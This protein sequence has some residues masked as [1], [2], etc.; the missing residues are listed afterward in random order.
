MLADMV[1]QEIAFESVDLEEEVFRISENLEPPALQESIREVG[2]L[3][4]VLVLK[5]NSRYTVLCGFRRAR[6]IKSLGMSA[7]LARILPD[8]NCDPVRA[9]TIAVRDNL[10]H[11]Q[12]NP[13][14]NARILFK[15]HSEFGLGDLAL[16][17]EYLP[18]LGLS[19]A[20]TVLRSYLRLHRVHPALRQCLADG[21][22]TLSSIEAL[23]GMPQGV[24]DGIAVLMGKIR[25]SASLQKK[26]LVLLQDLAGALG[27][28]PLA[29][30]DS[31]DVAAITEDQ[32]L[33][34]FQKGE[35]IFE[36]VYRLRN[37]R[38][39]QAS[40]QFQAKRKALGLAGSIR[41]TAHPFFEE[42]GLRVEF[43][44]PN[45][46]RFRE[47]SALLHASAESPEF[48]DLFKV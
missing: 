38:L 11:R 40:D 3:N 31:P 19:P 16:I 46:A 28:P 36:S 33:S 21:R 25:L 29:V 24:Q 12:L 32:R 5:R 41:I 39:S 15:L 42:P 8:E 4:P 45:V 43:E 26:L 27:E 18:L 9:Y 23:S 34:P 22:L 30:L 48:E 35:K 17:H 6:A 2:Q 14:E 10:S 13:L 7:L 1:I 47:L 20:E 44:A 37:P